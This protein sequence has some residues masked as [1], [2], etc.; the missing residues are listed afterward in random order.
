MKHHNEKMPRLVA[1]LSLRH[2]HPVFGTP[3]PMGAGMGARV[4]SLASPRGVFYGE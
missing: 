1:E 4:R 2:P 3:L